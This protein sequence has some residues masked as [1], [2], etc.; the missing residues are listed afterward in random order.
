MGG[1]RGKGVEFD[2]VFDCSPERLG[3]FVGSVAIQN[4]DDRFFGIFAASGDLR[5]E[6]LREPLIACNAVCPPF[7]CCCNPID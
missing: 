5:Y 6:R 1:V 3:S 4:Q 7:R 2:V